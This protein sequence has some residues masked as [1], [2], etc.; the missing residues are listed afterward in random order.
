M[1]TISNLS[2]DEVYDKIANQFDYTRVR[3][4]GSVK[5][6][7]D[8]IPP[9]SKVLEIGCGNGKNMLYRKDLD[10]FGI[11]LSKKQIE[12]CQNKK[13][14]VKLANMT[15]LPFEDNFFD[16]IIC[17]ATYHHLD[18]DDDR[19]KSLMEMKRVLN[20]NNINSK[21]DSKILIT[22]WAME[23]EED[24]NFNFSSTNEM[25][26]WKSKEDGNTY[27]RYY[28]IYR[29]GELESE[30]RKLWEGDLTIEKVEYEL[31]NWSLILF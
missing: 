18:N 26:P 29:K 9:N 7:L 24:S 11:D 5:R 23:Q 19:K 27:L 28:H 4:W 31:G 16:Y 6:F 13:L 22:T 2:I 8:A 30:I 3:I 21:K 25:V 15:D 10:F 1:T 17:I 14:N 12:I 20:K